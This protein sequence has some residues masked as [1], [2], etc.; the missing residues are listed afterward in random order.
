MNKSGEKEVRLPSSNKIYENIKNDVP[1]IPSK[2]K[3]SINSSGLI[4]DK[5]SISG[6][7]NQIFHNAE[8]ETSL[9]N[10]G[11]KNGNSSSKLVKKF[12]DLTK[13]ENSHSMVNLLASNG[14]KMSTKGKIQKVWDINI[15][16]KPNL[17][18]LYKY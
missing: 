18:G 13:A 16:L 6:S 9:P 17:L 1:S 8:N 12:Q 2:N 7:K 14:D 4:N 3:S 5:N 10:I 15:M 11:Q